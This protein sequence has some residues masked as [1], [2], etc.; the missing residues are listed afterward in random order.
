MPL[1][2]IKLCVGVESRSE[3]VDWQRRRLAEMA[4]KGEEELLRHTTRQT[5]RRGAEILAGGSLYWVIRGEIACRQQIVDLRN[6]RDNEGIERCD[7]CLSPLTIAVEPRP[8]RPFQGW[9]YFLAE[10][11]PAD[12]G[13]NAEITGALPDTLR[14]ELRILGVG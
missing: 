3:L 2:L 14:R 9:R 8:R 7:I 5:P 10:D 11:A 1:H 12:L 6:R 13:D 4:R